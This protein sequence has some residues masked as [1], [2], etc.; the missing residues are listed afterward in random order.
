MCVCVCVPSTCTDKVRAALVWQD[1]Q[2][3]HSKNKAGALE[4]EQLMARAREVAKTLDMA[5]PM[6]L[7]EF[8]VEIVLSLCKKQD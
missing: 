3:V 2:T 5:C 1:L 4:A 8:D 6:D 7:C